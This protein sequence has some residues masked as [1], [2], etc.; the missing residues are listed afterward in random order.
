MAHSYIYM[1]S[2]AGTLLHEGFQITFSQQ[3]HSLG[4]YSSNP[5]DMM[6]SNQQTGG[7]CKI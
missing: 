2:G 3:M 4:K 5:K 1:H 7:Y 6:D